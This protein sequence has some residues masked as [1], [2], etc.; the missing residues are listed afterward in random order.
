MSFALAVTSRISRLAL[1]AALVGSLGGA[2]GCGAAAPDGS[3]G[4]TTPGPASTP[5]G[6]PAPAGKSYVNAAEAPKYPGTEFATMQIFDAEVGVYLDETALLEALAETKLTFFGELHETAPVQELE[7]W[8]LQRMTTK[9]PDVSLAM[10]HFQHDEQPVLDDYLA[11]K[12][13]SD[14]FEKKSQPWKNYAKYWKPLVD[15]MK[16][17]GRPVVGLNVPSEALQSIYG[18]YPKTPLTV[19]NGWTSAF[20]YD[21][22]IAPRPIAA[23]SA[24][25][26]S[27]FEANFDPNAHSNM[28]MSKTEA[29]AYFT[30]L[31]VIRDETMGY[32]AAETLKKGGRVLTVAGDF[33]VQ[34][35]LA[36]PDRAARF[37]GAGAGAGYRLITTSP[38]AKLDEARKATV[39]DRKL[40]RFFLVYD[41]K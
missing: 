3:P 15:H 10:E 35:G 5:P 9:H 19:F 22:D 14:E 1:S 20:K 7:L 28:G 26:N 11:G 13:E 21:A 24:L 8:V 40:A 29:L 38:T 39:G 17:K 41:A 33:H 6:T 27:Y 4:P 16:S 23:G 2:V 31:A 25:Y 30:E 36:T 12:I 34:T 32:F 18:A 37:A